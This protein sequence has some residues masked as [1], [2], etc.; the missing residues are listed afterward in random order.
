M[1]YHNSMPPT[2]IALSSGT[3]TT[4]KSLNLSTNI[5]RS[6]RLEIQHRE[7]ERPR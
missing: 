2:N 5:T 3:G 7:R 6:V 4:H 1:K